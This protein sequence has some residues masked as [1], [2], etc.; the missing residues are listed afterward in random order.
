METHPK[1]EKILKTG[2][3]V[4][5]LDLPEPDLSLISEARQLVALRKKPV[6]KT[7]GL[8]ENV[9]ALFTMNVKLYQAALSTLVMG[10]LIF[11]FS[12]VNTINNPEA[13][14]TQSQ[15]A[16]N[17]VKSSTVLTSILTLV[18]RD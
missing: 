8:W 6:R 9:I 4:E 17:S 10:G 16:N 13:S 11:Y 7:N 12:E 5:Q 2:M 3:S 1:L 14:L 18:A 15:S